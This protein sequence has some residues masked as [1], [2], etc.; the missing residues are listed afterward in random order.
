MKKMHSRLYNCHYN[1]AEKIA[2]L[3]THFSPKFLLNLF[4]FFQ[5]LFS[6]QK[7]LDVM[8]K[9]SFYPRIQKFHNNIVE[10]FAV[11]YTSHSI[12]IGFIVK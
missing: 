5:N 4:F 1:I 8:E 2:F 12:T 11:F 3:L 9:K 7:G 10:K 6:L